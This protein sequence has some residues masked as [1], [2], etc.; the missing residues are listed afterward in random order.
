MINLINSIM[1]QVSCPIDRV[2]ET[3][4][5]RFYCIIRGLLRYTRI[6]TNWLKW[7]VR[8]GMGPKDV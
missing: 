4:Q 2:F 3:V 5:L 8:L 7:L 1:V 6:T